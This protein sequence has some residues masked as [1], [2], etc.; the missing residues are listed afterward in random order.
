MGCYLADDLPART[1]SRMENGVCEAFEG[2]HVQWTTI[3]VWGL[4]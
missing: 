1:K 3:A 2:Q 4:I